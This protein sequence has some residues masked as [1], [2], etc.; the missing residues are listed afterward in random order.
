MFLVLHRSGE[1]AIIHQFIRQPEIC[2]GFFPP[3]FAL[4]CGGGPRGKPT[5]RSESM[6]LELQRSSNEKAVPSF[7]QI[8][9]EEGKKLVG[10]GP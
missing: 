6:E 7:T 9:L 2:E 8:D 5:A 3:L 10:P 1:I 4:A